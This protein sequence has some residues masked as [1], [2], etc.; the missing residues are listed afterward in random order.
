MVHTT[1]CIKR[2]GY[3]M[4]Y[5]QKLSYN[6]CALK[7]SEDFCLIL[8]GLTVVTEVTKVTVLTIVTVVTIVALVTVITEVTGVTGKTGLKVT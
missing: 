1:F 5:S 7:Y 3:M 4:S 6:H 8:T 2:G